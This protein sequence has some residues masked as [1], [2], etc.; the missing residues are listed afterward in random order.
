M[1]LFYRLLRFIAQMLFLVYLR[2]RAFHR[3]RVPQNGPVLLACNHQSFMD[4]VLA[5]LALHRE[6]NFMARDTL[7]RQRHFGR[8]INGLNAFPVR[9][10]AGDVAAVKEILRRLRDGGLVVVFP[11]ATRTADGRTGRVNANAMAIAKKSAATIVPTVIDGAFDAWPRHR[12]VPLPATVHV[13][14][15]RPIT[16]GELADMTPGQIAEAVKGQWNDIL[17][18]ST[19]WRSAGGRGTA[20][21]ADHSSTGAA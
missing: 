3:R 21:R 7:F 5:A 2:G 19:R 1:R 17:E 15:G 9:R 13:T 14:Y 6:A 4:P 18:R 16:A 8:L 10:G 20:G 11:E 12:P